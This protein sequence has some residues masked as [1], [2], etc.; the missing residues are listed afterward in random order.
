MILLLIVAVLALWIVE[1]KP[2]FYLLYSAIIGGALGN[3]IDRLRFGEVIDFID[4]GLG[5][6]LRWP[7]FN[8]ADASISIS[9]VL[10]LYFSLKSSK[11][12]HD[13]ITTD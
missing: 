7:V 2:N 12:K 9:V 10:L 1:N 6:N 5:K 4:I 13:E 8:I 11:V 3:L